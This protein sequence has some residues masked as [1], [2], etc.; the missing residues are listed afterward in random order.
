MS[1]S[2]SCESSSCDSS[3]CDE[4]NFNPADSAH[5]TKSNLLLNDKHAMPDILHPDTNFYDTSQTAGSPHK[6]FWSAFIS[7]QRLPGVRFDD[8]LFLAMQSCA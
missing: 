6:W 8:S 7:V 4:D 3:S 1:S 2:D 5:L